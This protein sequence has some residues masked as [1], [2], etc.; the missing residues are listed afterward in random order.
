MKKSLWLLISL[1]GALAWM[2][3]EHPEELLTER[4]Q[5]KVDSVWTLKL[6]AYRSDGAET[7]GLSLDNGEVEAT[8]THLRSIWK[9]GESVYVY[10]GLTQIGVLNVSP[11]GDDAHYA[12]LSGNVV[13]TN[14]TAGST[15]LTLIGPVSLDEW[16]YAGQAGRLLAQAND[17][18]KSIESRYHVV[19][20]Q[21]V[22]VT[23][24]SGNNITTGTAA[25]QNQQSIYRLSFRYQGANIPAE[26]VTIQ[27][28]NNGLWLSADAGNGP[29]SVVLDGPSAD[30]FFVALRNENTAAEDLTF[31]VVGSDGVTYIGSKT[32]PAEAKPNGKFVSMKNTA[33]TERM[34]METKNEKVSEAL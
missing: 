34:R 29:V 31:Q 26:R 22:L 9:E 20:A 12:T 10:Q 13:T 17:D 7:K 11:D 2:G 27:A 8:A 24:I 6:R 16:T 19:Q 32:I 3:C 1:A 18:G 5:E 14:L 30:P 33:L 25:F 28:A 23:D 15:T 21:N 4:P